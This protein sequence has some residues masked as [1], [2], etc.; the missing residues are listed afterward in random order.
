[1]YC[2]VNV[3]YTLD[4][5]YVLNKP[6]QC[7]NAGTCEKQQRAIHCNSHVRVRIRRL[8]MLVFWKISHIYLMDDLEDICRVTLLDCLS[9][10][11]SL[12]ERVLSLLYTT[13][14]VRICRLQIILACQ[15]FWTLN[16]GRWTL[17]AGPWTV[18]TECQ[19]VD[20]KI[21]KF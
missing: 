11:Q 4:I 9:T 21:L 16:S 12:F 3:Y 19:T 20:V 8:Q 15:N 14:F 13:F 1:M 17:D 10:K 2:T 6:R 18:G 5:L 7:R